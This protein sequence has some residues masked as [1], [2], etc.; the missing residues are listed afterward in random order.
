MMDALTQVIVWLNAAANALGWL[1]APVALLPG[2]LSATILAAVSGVLLLGVF[3]YTSNQK[4]IKRV[5]DDINANMLALKLFKDSVKVAFRAQGRLLVGAFWLFLFGLVPLL[6]MIVPVTLLLGQMSLWYQ[7][8]PLR[9]GEETVVTLKLNGGSADSLP[10][11]TL[12]SDP[13][14]ERILGPVRI[15][16]KREVCWNIV[17]REGGLHRLTFQVGDHTVEK[18]LAVSDG[19]MRVSAVRP[20]WD[21]S[22][23]LT[24]PWERPFPPGSSIRSIEIDYPRRVSWTSGSDWWV[25]YWF[26]VSLV[27][28]FCFKGVLKVNV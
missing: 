20:G 2:W 1:L 14:A 25:V 11:V 21:W 17:A 12:Q 7:Q 13:A 16:S 4:A 9:V 22:E 18:E 26:G 27:A 24:H 15:A 10:D 8:R 3:K 28:A 19:F 5:R 6:V 23:V